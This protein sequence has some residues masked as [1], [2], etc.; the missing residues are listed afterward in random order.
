MTTAPAAAADYHPQVYPV[1]LNLTRTQRRVAIRR[2]KILDSAPEAEFDD[3][4][5]LPA[6]I[7]ETQSAF[8]VI[9]AN[10]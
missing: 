3:I 4:V 7:C 8:L 10:G 9:T 2:F 5:M 6:C 1:F